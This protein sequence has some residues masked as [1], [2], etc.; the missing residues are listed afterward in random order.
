MFDNES[1]SLVS[2]MIEVRDDHAVSVI[3]FDQDI[4]NDCKD[5]TKIP[6]TTTTT[7]TTTTMTITAPQGT[8]SL[9]VSSLGFN[10]LLHYM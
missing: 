2:H 5:F 6:T 9:I 8:L 4:E 10:I 7:T 1:W 3:S